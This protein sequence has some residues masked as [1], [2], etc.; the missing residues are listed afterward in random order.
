MGPARHTH[1]VLEATLSILRRTDMASTRAPGIEL[2]ESDPTRSDTPP[3]RPPLLT[4]PAARATAHRP[5]Y[6]DRRPHPGPAPPI[7]YPPR[8]VNAHEDSPPATGIAG[9]LSALPCSSR[10]DS[11]MHLCSRYIYDPQRFLL[12]WHPFTWVS[13]LHHITSH[14][15]RF[16]L[17]S[18]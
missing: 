10:P 5:S 18:R 15:Q 9:P 8:L 11:P 1:V 14:P 6:R 7:L 3:R 13:L 16:L 12:P 2:L 4:P 17:P